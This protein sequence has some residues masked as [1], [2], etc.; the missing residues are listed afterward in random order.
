MK[1]VST[2]SSTTQRNECVTATHQTTEVDEIILYLVPFSSLSTFY[3]KKRKKEGSL[4]N[5]K[6]NTSPTIARFLYKKVLYTLFSYKKFFYKKLHL[7]F[8]KS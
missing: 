8:P 5:S 6:C 3:K 1:E 4:I 2:I 7:D